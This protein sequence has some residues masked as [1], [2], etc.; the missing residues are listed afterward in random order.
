MQ[1]ISD[2]AQL[3]AIKQL[4]AEEFSTGRAE[5]LWGIFDSEYQDS[6]VGDFIVANRR[7]VLKV[8]RSDVALHELVVNSVITRDADGKT[9]VIKSHP[10]QGARGLAVLPLSK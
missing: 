10:E 5:K 7:T 9:Y 2:A 3:V 6:S 4:G 8:R 1:L